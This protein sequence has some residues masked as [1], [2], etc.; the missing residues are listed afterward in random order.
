MSGSL[1]HVISSCFVTASGFKANW[2]THHKVLTMIWYC[3]GS[4][5]S[6]FYNWRLILCASTLFLFFFLC[7]S[8][9]KHV[10]T[11]ILIYL[12]IYMKDVFICF[13]NSFYC[14]IKQSSQNTIISLT[15]KWKYIHAV[16]W[17]ILC[18]VYL[19]ERLSACWTP[20]HV[21]YRLK[22]W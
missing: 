2:F 3:F 14:F 9:L 8:L 1:A 13:Y 7:F 18:Q 11:F 6:L 20:E 22:H 12:L 21:K 15:V 4:K 16:I 19:F 10:I 17:I 5:K